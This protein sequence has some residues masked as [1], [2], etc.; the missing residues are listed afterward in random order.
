MQAK[1]WPS[2][3]LGLYGVQLVMNLAWQ[4]IFFLGRSPGW[5]QVDNVGE[6]QTVS[7][8]WSL[9]ALG[10]RETWRHLAGCWG[11]WLVGSPADPPAAGPH[12][13]GMPPVVRAPAQL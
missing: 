6:A 1:G 9:V 5:A 8:L 7:G 12:L 4:L 10:Y 3:E 11:P 13:P 2:T